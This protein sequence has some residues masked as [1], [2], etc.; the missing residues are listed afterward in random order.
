MNYQQWLEKNH[1]ITFLIIIDSMKETI[2]GVKVC[3]VQQW[4]H[5]TNC[6]LRSFFYVKEVRETFMLAATQRVWQQVSHWLTDLCVSERRQ[7]LIPAIICICFMIFLIINTADLIRLLYLNLVNELWFED[8]DFNS[9][10]FARSWMDVCGIPPQFF[11]YE[12][13]I[14]SLYEKLCKW[15]S[16]CLKLS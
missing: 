4:Q 12:L 6:H 15:S 10:V 2:S 5:Y 14:S 11:W 13:F 9:H 3:D 1:I 8:W 16:M 7:L